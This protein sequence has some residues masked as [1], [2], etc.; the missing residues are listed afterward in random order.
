MPILNA[1]FYRFAPWPGFREAKAPLSAACRELGLR[2]T[3][4][5]APEGINGS[6][7]GDEAG[8]RE[9]VALIR[10]MPQFK[11]LEAKESWSETPSFKR[12]KLRLKREIIAMGGVEV[13]PLQATG[14]RLAPEELRQWLDEG[15][16]VLLVDTRNRFE[17]AAGTFSGALDLGLD[18]FHDFP[19]RLDQVRE[20][21]GGRP[22]V[23]FCTG[24]IRC[25]KATALALERGLE[26]VYQLEGG[27]L[28]YFERCGGRHFEGECFVFDERER[29]DPTLVPAEKA[30]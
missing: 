27:I 12:M 20:R 13:D 3:I 22:V 8:V 9:L 29:L 1:A 24:G 16:E 6:I 11:D 21:L 14:A 18:H 15:K 25:E 4:L 30:C 17:V 5:L 7:C 23:M 26:D 2:G 28:R 10:R 19:A